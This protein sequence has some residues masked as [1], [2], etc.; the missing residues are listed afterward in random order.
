MKIIK[1]NY[2]NFSKATIIS[3]TTPTTT[4]NNNNNNNKKKKKKKTHKHWPQPVTTIY[5][6]NYNSLPYPKS[7][8][9]TA[10]TIIHYHCRQPYHSHTTSPPLIT[11][12]PT[13]LET[14][15]TKLNQT[16]YSRSM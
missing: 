15:Q 6:H 5:H 10:I 11:P 3:T 1:N 4:N 13:K 7:T 12:K 8:K 14:T 16:H 9:P 2:K